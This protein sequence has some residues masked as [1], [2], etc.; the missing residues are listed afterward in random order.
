MRKTGILWILASLILASCA[1]LGILSEAQTDFDTG[2]GLFNRGEYREAVEYFESATSVDPNFAEAYI[3]LGR[4]YLNLREYG[5][6]LP[7]L[8]TAYNLAPETV[9]NEVFNLL[10]DALFG[11]A[12]TELKKGNIGGSI[13]RLRETLGLAPDSK[14]AKD[15]LSDALITLG[16]DFLSKGNIDDAIGAY[17][18]ALT[19][20][21]DNAGAYLGLARAFLENGDVAKALETIQKA[22]KVDPKNK[23]VLKILRDILSK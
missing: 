20:S 17:G 23:E 3:Y 21:P 19:L 15:E 18:E 16:R 13:D 6:A 11:V 14:R 8:R 9:R 1:G 5:K 22:F 7:A 2:L 12:T 10:I 4:S